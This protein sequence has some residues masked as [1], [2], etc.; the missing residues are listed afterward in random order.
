LIEIGYNA[1][2]DARA[3][4]RHSFSSPAIEWRQLPRSGFVQ[5]SRSGSL[6]W[7]ARA[8]RARRIGAWGN[9][10][11]RPCGRLAVARRGRQ[12]NSF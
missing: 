1:W 3:Y 10:A 11:L 9:C 8:E 6:L 12:W 4:S 5:P 7:P 2:A